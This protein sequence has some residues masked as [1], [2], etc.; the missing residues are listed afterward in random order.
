MNLGSDHRAVLATLRINPRRPRT[1][2]CK[3]RLRGWQPH[4]DVN[5][6]PREFHAALDEHLLRLRSDSTQ[7]LEEVILDAASRTGCVVDVQAGMCK[8]WLSA[9]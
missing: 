5:N 3:P 6:C 7:N 9:R 1:T 2:P 8:P 4:L